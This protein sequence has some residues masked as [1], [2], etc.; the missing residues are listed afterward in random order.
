MRRPI[1]FAFTLAALSL[2]AVATPRAA[3]ADDAATAEAQ[4]R[5]Q[6]GL[7]L[8]DAG[9]HE[10]ARL[11]FQQAWSVFKSPTVLYNLARAEQLTGHDIEALEHFRQFLAM[12]ADP[13]I[14]DAT[15]EKA[16]QNVEELSKK[17]AHVDI[18]AP[19]AARVT[20]DGKPIED[21]KEPV[22]VMPG[23]HVIEATFEGKVRSVS[24]DTTAGATTPAKLAFE[25]GGAGNGGFTE[26][27][28]AGG[29]AG[30]GSTKWIVAG[31][32]GV[33]GLAG[34]GLGVGFGLSSQSAK[35]DAEALRRATPGICADPTSAQCA[36][37]DA[38]RDDAESAATIST[39][40]Y[41]AGGVLLAGAVAAVALWPSSS[42]QRGQAATKTATT[43]A[44][45][46]GHGALGASLAGTF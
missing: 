25:S 39:V 17:V 2:G 4:S 7:A 23:R 30:G 24:V 35:D 45:I 1:L 37:Y 36:N 10:A 46:L 38:K 9:S 33:A 21:F 22:P 27:P 14:T 19:P 34:L 20:I 11:K 28:P 16:R 41:I 32:L 15:R 29:D 44:P 12:G 31:G 40:G 3:R 13:R 42:Q 5:F 18:E 43:V 6:E 8:A 26:P